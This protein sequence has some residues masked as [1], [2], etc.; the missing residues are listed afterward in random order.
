MDLQLI[1]IQIRMKNKTSFPVRDSILNGENAY[2]PPIGSLWMHPRQPTPN[3]AIASDS[4][5][6]Y[7]SADEPKNQWL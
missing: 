7:R 4:P 3:E 5:F 6:C 1:I 2:G